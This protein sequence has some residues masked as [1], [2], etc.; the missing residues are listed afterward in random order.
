MP[1]DDLRNA[2]QNH[3]TRGRLI[4]HTLP[5][6]AVAPLIVF[7]FGISPQS[8]WKFATLSAVLAFPLVG[9]RGMLVA[10]KLQRPSS[11]S[12]LFSRRATGFVW[13]VLVAALVLVYLVIVK[14]S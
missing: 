3:E 12:L 4:A 2:F 8:W 10:R 9:V 1:F 7:S 14:S 13:A 11:N 6:A 5:A